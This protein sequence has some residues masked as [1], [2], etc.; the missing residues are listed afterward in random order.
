M[1]PDMGLSRQAPCS[2]PARHRGAAQPGPAEGLV[3]CMVPP[4]HCL[5]VALV[6]AEACKADKWLPIHKIQEV[7]LPWTRLR[8][9]PPQ[10]G[11]PP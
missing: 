2:L 9:P 4:L 3:L 7:S 5:P 10:T 8:A 6:V 11:K 1:R